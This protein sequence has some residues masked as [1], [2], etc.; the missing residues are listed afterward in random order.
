MQTVLNAILL[1]VALVSVAAILFRR[2]H[3]VKGGVLFSAAILTEVFLL[4]TCSWMYRPGGE[5]S[6]VLDLLISFL[7]I[8]SPSLIWIAMMRISGQKIAGTGIIPF[9]I[10][11]TVCVFAVYAIAALADP[12]AARN[13][14]EVLRGDGTPPISSKSY[15]IISRLDRF[16]VIAG[17]IISLVSIIYVWKALSYYRRL[18]KN[19]F[20]KFDSRSVVDI[21][22]F[23]AL[24][25]LKTA[26][27]LI[28]PSVNNI[29]AEGWFYPVRDVVCCANYLLLA[30]IVCRMYSPEEE[31][32]AIAESVDVAKDVTP[33]AYIIK[34]RLDKLEAEYFFTNPAVNINDVARMISVN[35]NYIAKYIR[36]QYN[37]TFTAYLSYLRVEYAKG[38]LTAPDATVAA[39]CEQVGF[40][41]VST[42]YRNFTALIGCSPREFQHRNEK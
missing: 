26:L 21:S 4:F 41:N 8:A 42:F 36:A 17:L 32:E 14:Y 16:R 9:I 24:F 11:I 18:F 38:L 19:R 30:V 3:S 15:I 5:Y 10:C 29:G 37:G 31:L 7:L 34:E 40:G 13:L 12:A 39:V 2:K 35:R 28:F 1:V 20:P 22:L 27:F 33:S 23:V 25:T 6:I